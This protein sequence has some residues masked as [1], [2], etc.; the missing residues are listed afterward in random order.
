MGFSLRPLGRK[1]SDIF[2]ANMWY[3]SIR[4]CNDCKTNPRVK[5]LCNRHYLQMKRHGKVIETAREHRPAINREGAWYLPL[6]I[7]AKQGYVQ[8]DEQDKWLD[9]YKWSLTHGYPCSSHGFLHRL[10]MDAPKGKDVDHKDGNLFDCRRGN[11][12]LCTRGQNNMN[13]KNENKTGFKGVYWHKA[14]N[15]Y[16]ARI[17]LERKS[18]HLGL[19]DNTEDAARAYDKKAIELFGEFAR[20]NYGV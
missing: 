17:M 2:D 8:I 10:V 7:G 6:G 15:K 11:L 4:M 19:F 16:A 13:R 1:I 14:A 12:R 5:N 3:T 9:K 20:L 18:Y